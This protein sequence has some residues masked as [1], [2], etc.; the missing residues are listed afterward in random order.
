MPP[1]PM[2]ASVDLRKPHMG[3]G[4]RCAEL[5]VVAAHGEDLGARHRR[6]ERHVC[7]G[8]RVALGGQAV[9]VGLELVVVPDER[10][11]CV[12]AAEGPHELGDVDDAAIG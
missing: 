5:A 2:M 1:E 3:E 4:S 12:L 6:L 10:P 9:E 11:H 7:E 8:Q